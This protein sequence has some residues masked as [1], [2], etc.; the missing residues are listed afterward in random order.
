MPTYWIW[1]CR[2]STYWRSF[3]P[4]L[5]ELGGGGSP[6]T[7]GS[8]KGSSPFCFGGVGVQLHDWRRTGGVQESPLTGGVEGLHLLEESEAAPL[9]GGVLEELHGM[10]EL[11]DLH[12]LGR[13]SRRTTP[14]TG[15]N[16]RSSQI[17]Q[18]RLS[19]K[20][21]MNRTA[22]GNFDTFL[23]KYNWIESYPG[24]TRQAGR[25]HR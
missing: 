4:F 14:L 17:Y 8:G 7:G 18:V 23:S 10:E 24:C 3:F 16:W 5:E 21:L 9:T 2:S 20:P 15:G 22:D 11:E 1:S 25:L 19:Q 6:L 12:L 13:E